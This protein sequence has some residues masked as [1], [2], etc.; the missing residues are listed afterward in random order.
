MSIGVEEL[1]AFEERFGNAGRALSRLIRPAIMP[2][3]GKV[4]VAAFLDS[5]SGIVKA[6][7][8]Y[9]AQS[10]KGGLGTGGN[11]AEWRIVPS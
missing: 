8:N 7:Q 11:L 4:I 6:V 5:Y 3:E 2:P 9:K 10:V 1:R